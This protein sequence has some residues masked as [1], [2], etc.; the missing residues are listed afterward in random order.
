ME[1]IDNN[2]AEVAVVFTGALPSGMTRKE[3]TSLVQSHGGLVE[4]R[5]TML[6][7][8][9]VAADINSTSSKVTVAKRTG[10][11]IITES[12]LWGMADTGLITLWPKQQ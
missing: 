10:V 2:L 3:A 4:D 6:T 7:T 12:E 1:F 5:V 8:H 9:L 11:T